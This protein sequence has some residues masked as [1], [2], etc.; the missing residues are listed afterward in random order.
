MNTLA[1]QKIDGMCSQIIGITQDHVTQGTHLNADVFA[2]A[3]LLE[4][5]EHLQLE[6]MRN[7][8]GI[9]RNGIMKIKPHPLM[10]L[11]SMEETSHAILFISFDI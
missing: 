7:S 8:F 6:P 5:W 4:V 3:L 1:Q 9:K 2:L 11:T 10:S